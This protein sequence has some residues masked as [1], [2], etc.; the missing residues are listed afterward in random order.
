M[1]RRLEVPLPRGRKRNGELGYLSKAILVAGG[2]RPCG[3]SGKDQI[4]ADR[5]QSQEIEQ[6][7]LKRRAIANIA[8]PRLKT[9]KASAPI[10]RIDIIFLPPG[11]CG[12]A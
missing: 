4:R 7:S 1:L 9:A 10:S 2:E 6:P 8:W 5:T 12:P 3:A 11:S